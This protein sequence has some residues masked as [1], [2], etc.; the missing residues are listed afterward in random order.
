MVVFLIC[1]CIHDSCPE[2]L[3]SESEEDWVQAGKKALQPIL[4][5]DIPV[6]LVRD[7]P[8]FTFDPR[9]AAS[10][11][12]SLLNLPIQR[13]E[14][15]KGYERLSRSRFERLFLELTSS[16]GELSVV[17][18]LDPVCMKDSCIAKTQNGSDIWLDQD[19]LS[20]TGSLELSESIVFELM[21]ILN[22]K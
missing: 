8:V 11:A 19:H 3:E 20:A 5:A 2:G 17:Q 18:L 15:D 12:R 13:F 9:Y 22:Q 14:I 10:V 6:V 21:K 16:D 7:L 1:G 4:D